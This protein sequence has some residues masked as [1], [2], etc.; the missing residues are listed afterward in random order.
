MDCP[1]CNNPLTHC[2]DCEGFSVYVCNENHC[3]VSFVH[4]YQED[5]RPVEAEIFIQRDEDD[6]VYYEDHR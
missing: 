6:E 5:V 4:I 3:H 2:E 1:N